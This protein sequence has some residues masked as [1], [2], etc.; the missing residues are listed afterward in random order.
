M[1]GGLAFVDIRLDVRG[2]FSKDKKA[3]KFLKKR[4]GLQKRAKR[5]RDEIQAVL[6]AQRKQQQNK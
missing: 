1:L 6:I 4:I 3:L 2:Y 5:K